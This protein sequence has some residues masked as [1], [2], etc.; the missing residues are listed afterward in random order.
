MPIVGPRA[1]EVVHHQIAAVPLDRRFETFDR[2]EQ[3]DEMVGIL[4]SADA[5]ATVP[6]P[7]DR[8]L[9]DS[10]T[11]LRAMRIERALQIVVLVLILHVNPPGYAVTVSVNLP[12]FA[13][14]ALGPI[15][16]PNR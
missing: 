1:L 5:D 6:Q 16:L 2:F 12:A 4:V 3:A 15:T 14:P 7:G 11:L 13:S 10:P 9:N 8:L